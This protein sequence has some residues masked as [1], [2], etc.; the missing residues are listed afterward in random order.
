MEKLIEENSV[1][2]AYV[3]TY[4]FCP[5][6]EAFKWYQFFE[7]ILLDG[8]VLFSFVMSRPLKKGGF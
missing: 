2:R 4:L 7:N 1:D 8:L 5:L 6:L 3:E